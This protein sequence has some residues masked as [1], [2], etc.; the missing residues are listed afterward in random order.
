MTGMTLAR[1]NNPDPRRQ[2]GPSD[3][4]FA[5]R[6]GLTAL[7][8][9]MFPYVVVWLLRP[10]GTAYTGV[11]RFPNDEFVYLSQMFHGNRGEWL[12]HSYATFRDLPP[13]AIFM[14]YSA[15]GKLQLPLGLPT[16]QAA[17]YQLARLVSGT[18]LVWQLWGLF[19]DVVHG[20]LAR[21]L[22]FIF[23]ILSAGFGIY[24]GVYK[25]LLAGLKPTDVPAYDL[26]INDSSVFGSMLY[27]PHLSAVLLCLV[28]YMR[29]LFRIGKPGAWR[30]LVAAGV[31]CGAVSTIH[32]EKVLVLYGA[33]ALFVTTRVM[34][35]RPVGRGVMLWR[36]A[37]IAL[38]G[39]PYL[40]YAPGASHV[41]YLAHVVREGL[42]AGAVSQLAYFLVGFGFAGVLTVA[43]LPR[44]PV[45]LRQDYA[46][47]LLLWSFVASNVVLIA[48]PSELIDHK[49]EGL[50]IGLAGLASLAMVHQVL[51]TARRFAFFREGSAAPLRRVS[52]RRRRALLVNVILILGSAT[53]LDGAFATPRAAFAS[54]R[55]ELYVDQD[56]R[57][58]LR[59]L[60]QNVGPT[61]SVLG[62]PVS[63]ELVSA[64]GGSRVVYSSL[65]YTPDFF[66]EAQ[67]AGDFFHK[68][69]TR[70]QYLKVRGVGYF[71]F[72]PR[73]Q[74]IT[75]RWEPGALFVPVFHSGATTIYRVALGS[76]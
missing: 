24:F 59:W 73:E 64:F 41:P 16:A 10:N 68:P 27:A 57:T 75:A 50:S 69:E 5:L 3:R 17:T 56:D 44:L 29:G 54:S 37:A 43:R 8:L 25:I 1:P 14:F 4:G 66:A 72:G 62:A 42:P 6:W 53:V 48:I 46:G 38:P 12:Y 19:G 65:S 32:P 60:S 70:L 20:R 49:G 36:A 76:F 40:L 51:P 2:E 71:Y 9:S 22:A 39:L 26:S 45:A 28:V 33:T 63:E 52:G 15:L 21:R 67:A 35:P 11:L 47:E 13:V 74:S 30:W 58:A 18:L 31:A 61:H 34:T 23:A 55:S 7:A